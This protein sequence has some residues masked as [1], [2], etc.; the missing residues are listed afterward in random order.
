MYNYVSPG[1]PGD[2][3]QHLPDA[4]QHPQQQVPMGLPINPNSPYQYHSHVSTGVFN[5]SMPSGN[6]RS[7]VLK[8]T[9]S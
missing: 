8:Q 4:Q 1:H 2:L 5:H 3:Y 7:Y 9:C 6:K